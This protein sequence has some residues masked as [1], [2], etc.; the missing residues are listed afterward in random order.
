MLIF[1]IITH[2]IAFCKRKSIFL[3][4]IQ[5]LYCGEEP[6]VSFVAN[7][8]YFS[9]AVRKQAFFRLTLKCEPDSSA[10]HSSEFQLTH[11]VH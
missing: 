7:D 3:K 6:T 1:N 8:E 5:M 11:R 4:S 9:L 2:F 10:E